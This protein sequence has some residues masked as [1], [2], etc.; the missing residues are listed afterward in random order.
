[1][2]PLS[3]NC[4]FIVFLLALALISVSTLA[5]AEGYTVKTTYSKFLGTYLVNQSGFTLYYF[6]NDS[7]AID[8]STC[9]GDCAKLWPPFYASDILVPDDLSEIDF[10][11]IARADGSKQTTFK[12]WPL[13]L[14]SR[15]RYP[16][17][18]NGKGVNDFW[19]III[20]A[21]Q[22]QKI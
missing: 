7:K 13:Y 22:S 19:H 16:E 4:S 2:N 6:Q 9:Y 15:D 8:N 10:G 12:G 3:R 20:P 5:W 18:T 17:D 14:Y 11:V 1:M 21:D